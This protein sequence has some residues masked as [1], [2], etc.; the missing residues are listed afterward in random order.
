MLDQLRSA[1]RE[2]AIGDRI[3]RL[4]QHEMMEVHRLLRTVL[5]IL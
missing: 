5:D 4:S 2:K 1:D 3:V